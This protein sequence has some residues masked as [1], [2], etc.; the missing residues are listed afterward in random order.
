MK[1]AKACRQC[2]SAKRRCVRTGLGQSCAPCLARRTECTL[3]LQSKRAK[4]P[5]DRVLQARKSPSDDEAP[6]AGQ[7]HRWAP[8]QETNCHEPVQQGLALPRTVAA[9][10]VEHYLD[11]IH[12]RPHSLFHP[13]TLRYDV[14]CGRV[15]KALLFAIC[16]VGCRF[17]A[18]TD[19]RLMEPWLTAESKR[20]LLAD[21]ENI[22]LENIQGC[23]L[24]ANLS[25][26]ES[27]HSS[28]AL[29]FRKSSTP[30]TPN[31]APL[32]SCRLM[33]LLV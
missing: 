8:D 33:R 19:I 26:A 32:L 3:T 27:R 28:E 6:Q 16:S 1:V 7:I 5:R 15:G 20:L 4:Q 12:D 13:P 10:L 18:K 22:C 9:E 21:L 31:E 14:R 2:R 29:F 24:V 25:A 23:I 30:P 17:S 11:K